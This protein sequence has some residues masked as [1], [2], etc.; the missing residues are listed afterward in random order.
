MKRHGTTGKVVKTTTH[1][2]TQSDVT[3][4][5]EKIS[6]RFTTDGRFRVD[7]PKHIADYFGPRTPWER[8]DDRK[9]F[10]HGEISAMTLEAVETAFVG[11]LD[12][13]RAE[14]KNT[15]RRKM[16]VVSFRANFRGPV[17]LGGVTIGN[18]SLTGIADLSFGGSPALGMSYEILWQI[19]DGLYRVYAEKEDGTP[20]QMTYMKA[21]PSEGVR[22]KRETF[23]IDWTEEREEF[24]RA[25]VEGMNV[26]IAKIAQMLLG[27]T[28]INVDRLIAGGGMLSLPA[29]SE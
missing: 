18:N 4:V 13:Y 23:A 9:Q 20:P 27:D 25:G 15:A 10:Y 29:P 7:L 3:Q 12:R 19:S 21:M 2:I 5:S 11:A 8:E 26:L 16:I 22:G 14:L 28:A 17:M 24:F 1:S 6:I